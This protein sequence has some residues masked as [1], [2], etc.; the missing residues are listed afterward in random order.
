MT[1]KPS[2]AS[3]CVTLPL[4]M[5]AASFAK[6]IAR[7]LAGNVQGLAVDEIELDGRSNEWI[8][9]VSFW[10]PTPAPSR[11]AA[12]ISPTPLH[13]ERRVLRID[14]AGRARR[15]ISMKAIAKFGS[16]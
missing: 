6:T 11:G 10:L 9:V 13:R 4:T 12:V 1:S 15:L 3:S 16:Q 14:A 7:R 2:D 5:L 8:V